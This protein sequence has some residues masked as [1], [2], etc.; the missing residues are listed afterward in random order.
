MQGREGWRR[1][2]PCQGWRPDVVLPNGLFFFFFPSFPHDNTF[3]GSCWLCTLGKNKT[4][5]LRLHCIV[6]TKKRSHTCKLINI[7]LRVWSCFW[8]M[9]RNFQIHDREPT[10]CRTTFHW[11][12]WARRTGASV[13]FW[14]K[15]LHTLNYVSQAAHNKVHTRTH[16]TLQ[17]RWLSR[18]CGCKSSDNTA[19]NQQPDLTNIHSV[20]QKIFLFCYYKLSLQFSTSIWWTS[21]WYLKRIFFLLLDQNFPSL[22]EAFFSIPFDSDFDLIR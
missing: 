1:R 20:S 21:I 5:G 18:L 3:L 22:L 19:Q 16:L 11:K 9:Q 12:K 7:N 14:Q 17:D 10:S 15:A 2:L 4:M 13:S 8:N 6:I